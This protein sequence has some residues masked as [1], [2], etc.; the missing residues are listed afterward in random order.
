MRK[1][2]I[3]I[4]V[5]LAAV[6]TGQAEQ[7]SEVY[8]NPSRL[9]YYDLLKVTEQLVVKGGLWVASMNISSAADKKVLVT[10]HGNI[11]AESYSYRFG[12]PEQDISENAGIEASKGI[13]SMPGTIFQIID[14][15]AN[16]GTAEFVGTGSGENVKSAI[17]AVAVSGGYGLSL[18]GDT[19]T[20][21]TTVQIKMN[22]N[23][24]LEDDS[25]ATQGLRLGGNQ[26]P[27]LKKTGSNPKCAT[28]VFWA[29]RGGRKVLACY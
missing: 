9:G 3:G 13:I 28:S 18:Y 4:F 23:M 11:P 20:A 14:V 27:I 15:L 22:S 16:G 2:L 12:S 21:N 17:N 26:I 6:M 24:T 10:A 29:D 1:I 19:L 5:L 25:S 8:F 7:I